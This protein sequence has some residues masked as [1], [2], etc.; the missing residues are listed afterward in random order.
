MLHLTDTKV[1]ATEGNPVQ[2]MIDLGRVAVRE[3]KEKRRAP[4][5]TFEASFGYG[6]VTS[7]MYDVNGAALD[8]KGGIEWKLG[9]EYTWSN[10]MGNRTAIF[11]FQK[12]FFRWRRHD[13][14]LYSS[15]VGRPLEVRQMDLKIGA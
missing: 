3:E 10:G 5:N 7:K 8:S 6:W 14:F 1:N 2:D 9:Y 12:V 15:G 13:A 11:R 4:A